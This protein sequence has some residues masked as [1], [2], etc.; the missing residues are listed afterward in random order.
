MSLAP[1]AVVW[2]LDGKPH[3]GVDY[4]TRLR[5]LLFEAGLAVAVVPLD[6]RAPSAAELRAPV[7]LLSGGTTLATSAEP[8]LQQA[9]E[10][11][12]GP[13]GRAAV[14]EALV[15]GVCL[16]AQLLA[17]QLLGAGATR[18]SPNG[19]EMGLH[20]VRG[21][22]PGWPSYPAVPH[23]H[24][25]EIRPEAVRSSMAGRV[26]LR[27]E[28]SEVEGFT[29][30]A[31]VLGIQFHP[32]LTAHDLE[33][34]VHHNAELLRRF[35]LLPSELLRELQARVGEW[36]PTVAED[37]LVQPVLRFLAGGDGVATSF[38]F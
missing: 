7:H 19:L 36:S 11:L 14:G 6:R 17:E 37:L 18:P 2:Q 4:G 12:V 3:E 26:V 38:A 30:G 24:Y 27:G 32:E 9:R 28:H 20:P 29:V 15:V 1:A 16:G 31:H 35:G 13:L 22:A 8:W 23:F 25:Y 5:D 21:G 34:M 33:R 10:A